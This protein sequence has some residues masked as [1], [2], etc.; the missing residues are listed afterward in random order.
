M[1]DDQYLWD[2]SGPPDPEIERLERALAPLR[3][4]PRPADP[5]AP[6]PWEDAMPATPARA[7]GARARA[8]RWIVA[9]GLACAAA[10]AL[11]L[12]RAGIAGEGTGPVAAPAT[13]SAPAA[14][15]AA[16]T[17][18]VSVIAGRPRID[19]AP[20]A[21]DSAALAP[22]Q[23]LVTGA[24]TR[25]SL[26]VPRV[27][28]LE[29]DP[30]TRLRLISAGPDREAAGPDR[31]APPGAHRVELLVGKLLVSI[32]SPPATFFVVTPAGVL[33]DLG[34]S[35]TVTV[36]GQGDGRI[37][38]LSGWIGFVEQ[39]R[40]SLVPAGAA[41]AIRRGRGPG[42]PHYADA[43][44]AFREA[45]AA[46]DDP[47]AVASADERRVALAAVLATARARDA[48]TLWHLL[49]RAP[50]PER[51][52]LLARLH[53]LVPPTRAVDRARVIAG[54]QPA[55]DRLWDHLDVGPISDWRRWS[56]DLR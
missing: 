26:A 5:S 43:P 41:C 48:V 11:W 42:T 3:L 44:S 8:A 52:R 36:D 25:V 55:L 2:R 1:S 50:V 6:A 54:E 10:V 14:D 30:G 31:E 47:A 9:G 40:E 34:C 51:R 35:Y 28:R 46:L 24:D 7:S 56:A 18:A 45:L 4:V 37:E 39:G 33:V 38:V 12:W 20:V 27:G 21:G 15:T 17:W 49:P 29:V 16:A 23:T 22:G 53:A 19:G 32:W 13:V